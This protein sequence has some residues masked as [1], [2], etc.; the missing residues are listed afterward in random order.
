M[1]ECIFCR[2]ASGAIPTTRIHETE[3]VL[4][5]PDIHPEAPVHVLI[6]PKEHYPTTIE[7]TEKAPDLLVDMFRA[8]NEVARKLG[9]D[10]SGFRLILN[11]N[12]DG[13]QEVFHVH[14]HL[15]A[16]EPVGKLRCRH[17]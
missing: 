15:L 14:M 10:K 7:L 9:V 8:A 2:I 3:T 17:E 5:F 13:G 4:A 1:N 11:T 16:G 12:A 6:I